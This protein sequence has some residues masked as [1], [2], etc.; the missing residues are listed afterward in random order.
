MKGLNSVD[1]NNLGEYLKCIR[2][3]KGLS[4]K[5]IQEKTEIS[6]SYIN[7]LENGSRINPSMETLIRLGKFYEI[8]P[9][10]LIKISGFNSN[11]EGCIDSFKDLNLFISE[12]E[13]IVFRKK[14]IP[15]DLFEK[16]IIKVISSN[17]DDFGELMNLCSIIK[18]LNSNIK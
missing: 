5:E 6:S 12:A 8:P 16:L 17:V 4:L 15:K 13:C 14:I 10:T 9:E 18:E 1:Y 11:E 3:A 2:K 7:R